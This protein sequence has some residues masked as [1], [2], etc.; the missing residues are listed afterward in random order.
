MDNCRLFSSP[1]DTRLFCSLSFFTVVQNRQI[2]FYD[3]FGTHKNISA[4]FIVFH[5]VIH[6]TALSHHCFLISFSLSKADICNPLRDCV[7]AMYSSVFVHRLLVKEG[8][9]SLLLIRLLLNSSHCIAGLCD[10]LAQLF[11]IDRRLRE[12]YRLSLAV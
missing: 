3:L 2:C 4:C 6:L 11:L 12:D 8:K 10:R 9:K 5:T 1:N 7:H